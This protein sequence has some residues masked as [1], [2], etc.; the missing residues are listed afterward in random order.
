MKVRTPRTVALQ[1]QQQKLLTC[2]RQVH[3]VEATVSSLVA[4]IV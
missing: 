4:I 3:L 1:V 2:R